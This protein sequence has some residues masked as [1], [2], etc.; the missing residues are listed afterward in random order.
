MVSTQQEK[1]YRP[2]YDLRDGLG[3]RRRLTAA[4]HDPDVLVSK[5]NTD[6]MRILDEENSLQLQETK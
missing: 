1:P 6:R 2:L 5:D 3:R 4:G